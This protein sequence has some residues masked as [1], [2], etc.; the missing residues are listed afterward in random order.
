MVVHFRSHPAGCCVRV[1]Q[2]SDG[3]V[4]T[5]KP[6][7][8]GFGDVACPVEALRVDSPVNLVVARF[9]GGSGSAASADGGVGRPDAFISVQDRRWRL[10]GWTQLVEVGR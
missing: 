2:P 10:T 8:P 9:L 7:A 4:V 5:G 6:G 3:I 1:R